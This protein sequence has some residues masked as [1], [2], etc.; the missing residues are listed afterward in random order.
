[1]Y[2]SLNF[3]GEI[4]M[5]KNTN[6][7]F[8]SVAKLFHWVTVLLFCYLFYLALTMTGMENGADK[9]ALYAEH[10]Q[11][12]AILGLIVALRIFWK[13][14]NS[15]PEQSAGTPLWKR[16]LASLTHFA[17]YL[18]ML[19]F[20]LSG[21]AMSMAGGHD[22]IVFGYMVPD[23]IGES[24]SIGDVAH[25][26]HGLLEYF[27]YAIVGFHVL[28]ALYHHFIEKDNVL[29]RMLPFGK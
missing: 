29:T 22:I 21:Y 17:L 11:Y 20:P 25:T 1:M 13:I 5:I 8:G 2:Y 27:T 6:K 3:N 18:I 23:L 4:I 9:W 10:K 24:K 16:K 19:G 7:T 15:T 28:A 26:I 14:T 12:G